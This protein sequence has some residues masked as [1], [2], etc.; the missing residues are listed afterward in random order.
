[1]TRRKRGDRDALSGLSVL[2]VEDVL[3]VAMELESVLRRFGCRVVGPVPRLDEATA[4]A[5]NE[6]I[7]GAILD[8][9][10]RGEMTLDLARLLRDRG[11]PFVFVTGYEAEAVLPAEFLGKPCPQKPVSEPDL[12]RVVTVVFG[13][14]EKA[15]G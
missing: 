7:D 3:L 9:N 4:L 2:I 15:C 10:I 14:R 1:M 6:K 5:R 13:E 8:L 11:V 12:K